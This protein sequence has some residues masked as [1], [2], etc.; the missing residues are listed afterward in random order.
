MHVTFNFN[1]NTYTFDMHAFFANS[2]KNNNPK[3]M[4]M[5]MY[6]LP[7]DSNSLNSLSRTGSRFTHS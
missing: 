4:Y 7:T 6:Y 2:F 5:Y 1:S 3:K